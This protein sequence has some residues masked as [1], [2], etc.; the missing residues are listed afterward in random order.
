[1]KLIYIIIALLIIPLKSYAQDQM[2]SAHDVNVSFNVP[3]TNIIDIASL[4][5]NDIIFSP[6]DIDAVSTGMD[7]SLVNNELWLNY[8]VVK[9]DAFSPKKINVSATATNFPQGMSLK[10]KIDPDAQQGKGEIGTPVFG[11]Q[12][13]I[14]DASP[15]EII[16]NIGSCFTGNGSNKGHNLHFKL[17]YDN[18]YYDE[19]TTNFNTI[20][21]LTYTIT[22]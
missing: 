8:T 3:K 10:L 20:I 13:L 16:S 14:P 21:I 5:G 15:I 19:L 18:T 12:N 17:D 11:F 9:S 7:F 2:E 6:I 22:D 1:M 4:N